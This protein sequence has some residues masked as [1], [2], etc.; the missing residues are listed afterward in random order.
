MF[1]QTYIQDQIKDDLQKGI[2]QVQFTKAD[3]SDRIM[4][5]TLCKDEI[6]VR[7][8]GYNDSLLDETGKRQ[9]SETCVVWDVD[10][11]D[12]RSFRWDRVKNV[13]TQVLSEMGTVINPGGFELSIGD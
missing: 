3:G 5:A 2:V 6:Q 9:T 4:K 7:Y 11:N 8:E 13:S 12:W 1:T 10:V